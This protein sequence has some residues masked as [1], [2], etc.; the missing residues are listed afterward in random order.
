MLPVWCF[1]YLITSPIVSGRLPSAAQ[2]S[3]VLVHP[4][5]LQVLPWSVLIGCGIPT[6]MCLIANPAPNAPLWTNQQFWILIR[7]VHPFLTAIAQLTLSMLSSSKVNYKTIKERNR[8]VSKG[9]RR[10]YAIATY[11]AVITHCATWTLLIADRALPGIFTEK[12]QASFTPSKLFAP[13]VFWTEA[14]PMTQSIAEGLLMFLQWDELASM[15]TIFVWAFA[16]NRDALYSHLN[17]S[18]FQDAVWQMLTMT[19]VGGPAAAAVSAIKERD[20]VTLE[21]PESMLEKKD[22]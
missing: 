7:Q 20:E 4:T 15:T 2:Q 12:Y 5:E 19:L 18:R 9:L 6:L 14:K 3:G 1:L 13:E 10:V 21:S 11:V 22:Q 17:G 8:D 16:L